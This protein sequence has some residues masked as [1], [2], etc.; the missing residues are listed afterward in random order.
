MTGR[1][2]GWS[3]IWFGIGALTTQI[4]TTPLDVSNQDGSAGS[5]GEHPC[6]NA[7]PKPGWQTGS[8][9]SP[10]TGKA[11]TGAWGNV[12]FARATPSCSRRSPIVLG[13][14]DSAALFSVMPQGCL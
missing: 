2:V 6:D 5:T 12:C 3:G 8:D 10:L 9:A 7:R 14:G 4:T 1:W 13:S 11:S